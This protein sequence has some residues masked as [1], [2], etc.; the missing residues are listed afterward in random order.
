MDLSFIK[1][2]SELKDFILATVMHMM[3]GENTADMW[4]EQLCSEFED[5][6]RFVEIRDE[7]ESIYDKYG[8]TEQITQM[9][10]SIDSFA[11]YRLSLDDVCDIIR[12][13]GN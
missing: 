1:D 10:E 9:V 5:P 12:Y 2:T 7:L 4:A 6:K 3:A 13:Y 8:N 11:R